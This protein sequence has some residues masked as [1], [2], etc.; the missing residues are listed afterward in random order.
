MEEVAVRTIVAREQSCV[1]LGN[2]VFGGKDNWRENTKEK[3][4]VE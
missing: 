3:R 4:K 2:V 1:W